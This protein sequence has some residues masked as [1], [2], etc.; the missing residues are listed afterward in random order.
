MKKLNESI[1]QLMMA[2]IVGLVSIGVSFIGDMNEKIGQV[3]GSMQE[4]NIKMGH[5]NMI[6]G[7]HEGRLREVEKEIRAKKKE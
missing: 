3:A 1:Y 6:V 7:D 2:L 5:V 4:M